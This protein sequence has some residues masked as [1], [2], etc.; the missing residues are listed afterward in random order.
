MTK[1]LMHRSPTQ[2]RT[3]TPAVEGGAGVGAASWRWGHREVFEAVGAVLV[4]THRSAVA[5]RALHV[6]A[7]EALVSPRR[8][9]VVRETPVSRGQ[10]PSDAAPVEPRPVS[11]IVCVGNGTTLAGLA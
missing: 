8:G 3:P 5:S 9:F 2:K 10:R 6:A 4:L 7:R 1:T 11:G